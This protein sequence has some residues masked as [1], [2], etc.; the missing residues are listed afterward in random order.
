MFAVAFALLALAGT[1]LAHAGHGHGTFGQH[2]TPAAK[3]HCGTDM[4][5]E[6]KQ[7]HEGQSDA[8]RARYLAPGHTLASCRM[9]GQCDDPAIRNKT[10]MGSLNISLGI[11]V[12]GTAAGLTQKKID[13]QIETLNKDWNNAN[14]NFV[15]AHQE[16]VSV[17]GTQ[18]LPKYDS[19]MQWY[20]QIQQ[21][22][23]D[24]GKDASK[25]L[26]VYITCQ[27]KGTQGTLLGF[28]TFPWDRDANKEIGG[29]WMN[30]EYVSRTDKTLSHEIG[31][32]LGLRHTFAGV[33]EVTGCSDPCAEKV[34]DLFAP[35]ADVVG[36][37][38]S[39]TRATPLNYY[40]SNPSGSSPCLRDP[41]GSTPINNYM[42]Y[43]GDTCMNEFTDQQILRSHCWTCDK[44]RGQTR[45]GC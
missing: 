42:S 30:A 21:W 8:Q 9:E 15:V 41:W 3:T 18:C 26:N 2:G 13:E 24:Y 35:E 33:Q 11:F 5:W 40:C 4:V 12:I 16:F 45:A 7:K 28:G 23:G 19:N 31:H 20:Y 29:I 32:N 39:D 17:Q 14:V 10:P 1:G 22:K 37:W 25:Q 34:H 27:D 38:C 6:H 43:T 36:D 44:I